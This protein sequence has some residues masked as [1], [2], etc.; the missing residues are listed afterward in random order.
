MLSN[1]LLL[2]ACVMGH[3]SGLPDFGS[4]KDPLGAP[5]FTGRIKKWGTPAIPPLDPDYPIPPVHLPQRPVTR[6]SLSESFRTRMLYSCLVD[7]DYLDTEQFMQGDMPRGTGDSL[8]TLLTRLQA[9]LNK[10]DSP[11][12]ELN[13]LRQQILRAC[14]SPQPIPRAFTRLR[15]R[16]AAAK[17]PV[18]SHLR[19]IMPLSTV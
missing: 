6:P 12:S 10:W 2:A 7:A 17:R 15:F 13:K 16:P 5:T 3:H 4:T 8:E 11:T 19:C 1:N 18:L 14:V 9:R